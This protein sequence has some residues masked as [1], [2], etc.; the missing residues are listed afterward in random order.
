SVPIGRPI[1]NTRVYVLD[2]RQQPVPVGVTGE[3][4]IGGDGT[5]LGYLQRE[6]LT[7]ERFLL[8]PIMPES[9][10]RFYRTGDLVRWLPSGDIEF[11]GRRDNQVKLRGVRIELGEIESVVAA[12][13]A[14]SEALALV[15]EVAPGDSRL[16]CYYVPAAG[17]TAEQGRIRA[18]LRR[19]LPQTMLPSALV[20][21]PSFP[22]TPNGKVDRRALPLPAVSA[23]RSVDYKPP[24]TTI[25]HELV[26]VWEQLLEKRPIGVREDFFELG[27]HS[28]LAVRM[29]AEIGRLRGRHVPL[30]WL[31]ES[32]TIEAL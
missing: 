24:R 20:E 14:V 29:L 19:S 31:F 21:L 27:G 28:L 16:L 18:A 26:Q 22:L 6:E 23:P 15:R 17:A 1:A 11:I 3:L 5:S 7:A 13:P 2:A 30:S 10:E 4:Y 8:D 12:D 32:S 25:E 9:G